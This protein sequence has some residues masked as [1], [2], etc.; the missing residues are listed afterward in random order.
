MIGLLH[1]LPTL[2]TN[3]DYCP[4][5]S[6]ESMVSVLEDTYNESLVF[7]GITE[8]NS[9]INVYSSPEGTWTMIM[10]DH[11]KCLLPFASGKSRIHYKPAPAGE[12]A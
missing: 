7:Q 11:N 4:G 1:P 2:A 3:I 10:I 9:I 8:R 6:L 12:P 5:P